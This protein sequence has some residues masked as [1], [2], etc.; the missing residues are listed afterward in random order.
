MATWARIDP[1]DNTDNITI[2]RRVP[3]L[4]YTWNYPEFNLVRL[5]QGTT[6]A[7]DAALICFITHAQLD[8]FFITFAAKLKSP[9][10]PYY[11]SK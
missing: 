4:N 1:S 2:T 6:R 8:M 3:E 5:L 10:G 11:H 7:I 9:S